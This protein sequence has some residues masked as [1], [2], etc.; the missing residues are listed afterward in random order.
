VR[1]SAAARKRMLPILQ[2]TLHN[3]GALG[4]ADAFS[5]PLVRGDVATVRG[6]LRALARLPL[7]RQVYVALAQAALDTLPIRN[8]KELQSVLKL[9]SPPKR[10]GR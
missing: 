6:H 7:A 4:P 2:Q 9:P 1:S 10:R 8:R 5:G 3:Y